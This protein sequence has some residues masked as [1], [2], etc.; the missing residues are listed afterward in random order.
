LSNRIAIIVA[1]AVAGVLLSMGPSSAAPMDAVGKYDIGDLMERARATWDTDKLDAVILLDR[2]SISLTEDGAMTTRVHR[3]VWMSTELAL[4]TYGDLRVPWNSE[5]SELR[6]VSLRTWRD[7]MWWPDESEISGT[8][9]VPTIP[10]AVQRAADYTGIR[11]TM[12]LHDGVELPCIV[13]TVYEVTE[14]PLEL[15]VNWARAIH[16]ADAEVPNG[17]DGMWVFQRYDPCVVSRLD[18]S[19]PAGLDLRHEALDGA[20]PSPISERS[21]QHGIRYTWEMQEL[22]RAPRPLTD[23]PEAYSARVIW[24]TWPDWR[25]LGYALLA[26]FDGAAVLSETLEDSVEA[27]VAHEPSDWS[28][29]QAVAE[30]ISETTR[31]VRYPDRFWQPA[32]RPA[33]RTWETAY[34]HRLDRAVLAAALFR[35][36]GLVAHPL[37]LGSARGMAESPTVASLSQLDGPFL[38]IEGPG[39]RAVY[40]PVASTLTHASDAARA[41]ATWT[42]D[43]NGGPPSDPAPTKTAEFEL[44]MEVVQ[45]EEGWSGTGYLSASG[46]MSPHARMLGLEDEA[47]RHLAALATS[48]LPGAE[49]S[50][51]SAL[52]FGPERV[53]CGFTFGF[54]A[55]EPD[56]HGRC[57]LEV[58][59]PSG[60]VLSR[61]PADVHL[62]AAERESPVILCSPLRQTLTLRI[63]LEDTE[64]VYVPEDVSISNAVGRFSLTAKS[65]DDGTLTLKR[66]LELESSRFEPSQWPALRELLLAETH[67]RNRTLLVE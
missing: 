4:E 1:L 8:A 67:E 14:R 21:E 31:P 43:G 60:S 66:A 25:T 15:P 35:E 36:T 13:E 47:S 39:L 33:G 7:D 26:T 38:A 64:A 58:G 54:D 51:W 55:G 40:D 12:L 34:A 17:R 18:V 45:E 63:M 41:L 9:V 37:Y 20:P 29:A 19:V 49:L 28:R 46:C 3:I 57:A 52:E 30:F 62:Y 44:L 6:V 56:D 61:M 53:V 11:E 59:D 5:T 10:G 24:S 16:G 2:E 50:Q 65:D 23:H 27:L 32:P 22:G 42:L 48:A